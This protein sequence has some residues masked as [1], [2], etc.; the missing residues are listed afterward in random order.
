M[1]RAGADYE[2]A[3]GS[4]LLACSRAPPC[5]I[6][7]PRAQQISVT[8]AL[9][10]QCTRLLVLQSVV[11][12]RSACGAI[13]GEL[14]CDYCSQPAATRQLVA[15]W[16]QQLQRKAVAHM[17]REQRRAAGLAADGDT[18][19]AEAEE[20]AAAA[21]TPSAGGVGRG[22]LLSGSGDGAGAAAGAAAATSS[23]ASSMAV[24]Q[25]QPCKPR[26]GVWVPAKAHCSSGAGVDAGA[27]ATACGWS[28]GVQ[29]Q[30][31]NEKPGL[32]AAAPAGTASGAGHCISTDGVLLPQQQEAVA[33]VPA[34][35]KLKRRQLSRQLQPWGAF[36]AP[37]MSVQQPGDIKQQ[38]AAAAASGVEDVGTLA[39]QQE[40]EEACPTTAAVA[41]A[42]HAV[43]VRSKAGLSRGRGFQPPFRR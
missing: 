34:K 36:K 28:A 39:Q 24:R 42:C 3:A 1:G 26:P 40:E 16:E 12:C 14:Q 25:Q 37:R 6:L 17:L 22:H 18:E 21:A 2:A 7:A 11:L 15:Q 4:A 10:H 29:Q 20:T 27:A 43:P 35:P 33:A 31:E 32:P 23:A 19:D 38:P 30:D 8:P 9:L 41:P 13:P 5:L